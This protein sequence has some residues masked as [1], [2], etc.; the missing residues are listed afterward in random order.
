MSHALVGYYGDWDRYGGHNAP[1]TD[2]PFSK[3]NALILA[4]AT[5]QDGSCVLLDGGDPTAI[6][7][8]I[9]AMKARYPKL[10][11]LLSVGGWSYRTYFGDALATP[12][13]TRAFAASCATFIHKTYPGVFDG[14]DVDWEYPASATDRAA[15]TR[16]ITDLRADLGPSAPLTF[17]AGANPSSMPWINWKAVMPKV[18]WINMLTYDYHGSWDPITDFNS[19]LYGDPADPMYQYGFWSANTIDILLNKYGVPPAKVNLGVPFYGY[20]YTGVGPTNH[21]LYQKFTAA[22]TFGAGGTNEFD[23]K[24]I[25]ANYVDKQGYRL[26]GPDPLSKELW[27]YNPSANGGTFISFDGVS[28]MR[29]K[30]AYIKREGLGGASIWD[31]GMDA[32]GHRSLTAALKAGLKGLG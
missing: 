20:G 31:M 28:S 26:Y 23:Y 1:I 21:G 25:I 4:F 24:D 27:V 13:K 9:R 10:R 2:V 14:I 30:A 6:F 7:P 19:P 22:A 29:A 16:L 3:L 11:V 5:P 15:F 12:A 17:A 18:S 32:P 8:T